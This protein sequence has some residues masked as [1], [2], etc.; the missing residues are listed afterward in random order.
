MFSWRIL[1]LLLLPVTS[2]A[3]PPLVKVEKCSVATF[4]PDGSVLMTVGGDRQVHFWSSMTGEE[5]NRFGDAV[6]AAHFSGDGSRVI[7]WGSDQIIRLFDARTGKALRRLGEGGQPIRTAAISP[8]GT[9]AASVVVGRN[10]I[11]VWDATSGRSMGK[12]EGHTA[13]VTALVFSPDGT[14]LVSLAGEGKSPPETAL[15]LWDVGTA[16]NVQTIKLPSEGSW[17]YFSKDGKLILLLAGTVKIYELSSG[18]EVERPRSEN[19]HF[20]P[21]TFTPDRKTGL[22]GAIGSAAVIDAVSNQDKQALEGPI[23]GVVLC[24][25]FSRD[26]SRVMT[27]TGKAALFSRNPDQP[28]TVYLFDATTGKQLAK[29]DGHGKQVVQ[30]GLSSDAKAG[31]SKDND[32]TLLLWK[33]P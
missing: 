16:K 6:T 12:C 23:D 13:T 3:A 20:P 21:G 7:T 29:L 26:G 2:W 1:V 19:E 28:G 9:R 14:Q 8:D 31:W 30:V 27:G 11:D 10:V 18:K 32:S 4:S 5:V 24:H 15:R 22:R 33:L 25:V 17:P